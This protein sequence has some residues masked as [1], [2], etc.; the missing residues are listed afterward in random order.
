MNSDQNISTCRDRPQSNARTNTN[1]YL[2]QSTSFV[3]PVQNKN[4]IAT[5]TVTRR[6]PVTFSIISFDRDIFGPNR[7]CP[8]KASVIQNIIQV[9]LTSGIS[10]SGSW[11]LRKGAFGWGL[12]L[13][14]FRSFKLLLQTQLKLVICPT[15]SHH[16][17]YKFCSRVHPQELKYFTDVQF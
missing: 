6:H 8:L 1:F 7:S 15:S 11:G 3:P 14:L 9:C 5:V 10:L 13:A 12:N 17:P 16:W 4:P 2:P